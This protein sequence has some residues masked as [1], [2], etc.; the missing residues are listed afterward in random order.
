ML[1]HQGIVGVLVKHPIE[2]NFAV[3]VLR[4]GLLKSVL[5][6]PHIPRAPQVGVRTR[7]AALS[8]LGGFEE[9]S[10]SNR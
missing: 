8:A 7:S 9:V 2:E 3:S 1:V 10:I 4:I 5:N 6:R